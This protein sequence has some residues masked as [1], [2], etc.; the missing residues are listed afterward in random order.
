MI[1][2]NLDYIT[3]IDDWSDCDGTSIY[4]KVRNLEGELT[5]HWIA[6]DD[7]IQ[8]DRPDIVDEFFQMAA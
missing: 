3:D 7:L 2:L 4:C 6:I 1:T 8:Y 5:W